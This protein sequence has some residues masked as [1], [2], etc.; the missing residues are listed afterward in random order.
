MTG[1]PDEEIAGMRAAPFWGD[2]EAIAYILP[3]D[4]ACL[5]TGQ[6]PTDRL[7][8]I[9]QPVLVLTGDDRPVEAPRWVRALDDAADAI[10]SAMPVAERDTFAR[11]SH[12][13]DPAVVADRLVR[14]FRD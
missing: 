8:T 4:A 2:L 9:R 7:R 11:Q 1:T 13:P 14:F 3:Y 12:L 5:G 6:P 10:A